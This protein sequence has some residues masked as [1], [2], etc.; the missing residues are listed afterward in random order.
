[1]A[2]LPRSRPAQDGFLLPLSTAASLL[3]MLS[4]LSLQAVALQS[5]SQVNAGQRLRQAEDQLMSAAQHLV[6]DPLKVDQLSSQVG[7]AGQVGP[8]AELL[9]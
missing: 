1:M 9:L 7:E 4:S 5:R 8:V 3:L 2:W 6:A